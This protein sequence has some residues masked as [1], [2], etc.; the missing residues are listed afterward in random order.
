MVQ[1]STWPELIAAIQGTDDVMWVGNSY[2]PE[3]NL[4]VPSTYNT[5][6][7][8]IHCPSIDFNGLRIGKITTSGTRDFGDTDIK[9]RNSW[10][11]GFGVFF[12]AYFDRA[13]VLKNLTVDKIVL[14]HPRDVLIK[15]GAGL[16]I[17]SCYFY[18]IY[19][20]SA[21]PDCMWLMDSGDES[22]EKSK[23]KSS[24]SNKLR[25]M[26]LYLVGVSYNDA[27]GWYDYT[28]G[29]TLTYCIVN[30]RSEN[31][32]IMHASGD[33]ISCELNY[34]YTF[35][36]DESVKQAAT[37]DYDKLVVFPSG[38]RYLLQ[39]TFT[40]QITIDTEWEIGLSERFYKSVESS[41]RYHYRVTFLQLGEAGYGWGGSLV[42][43]K[44]KVKNQEFE[45]IQ[46]N[47]EYTFAKVTWDMEEE[48]PFV[49]V[50]NNGDNR[51]QDVP[52]CCA[53]LLGDLRNLDLMR[54]H[55]L[56]T[57]EDDGV[58]YDQYDTEVNGKWNEADWRR[59]YYPA[60]NDG[61]PFLPF[62]YYPYHEPAP[63]G[64]DAEHNYISIYDMD[65]KQ[66]EFDNNGLILEP[67]RCTV[68]E[69]LNGGYNLT[70]E[71]PKD[72][73]GKWKHILEMNIIKCLGQLFIIRKVT[74]ATRAG[75]KIITAY[76][77]HISYHL[78][79]YWLFP[80]TSIAGYMGQTLI[81][82]IQAQMWDVPWDEEN[83]L[84]YT[85][86]IK[87]NLNADPTF[88]EWYE[89][90]EGHTPWE[91]ILG[92]N[93]FTQLIGGEVYR[94]NFRISIYERMEGA[95]DNAF[96]IHPD[97]NL[98]SITRTV[99][100]NTFCTYFR[101]YDEYGGW[102][103]IAWDPRTLP[104]SYPHNVVRSQNFTFDVDEEY[105]DFS[106]LARKTGEYF[107][108]VCAPLVSFKMQVQDLK[109]HPDYKDFV[110]NYRFKVGDMG[111]VWDD[112]SERYYELEITKTVKDGITGRCLE[113]TIGTERSFTRPEASPVE[114]SKNFHSDEVAE[115]DGDTP[116]VEEYWNTTAVDYEYEI[117]DAYVRLIKYIGTQT[118]II[119]P[120]EIEGKP[121]RVIGEECFMETTIT[122]V[123]MPNSVEVIE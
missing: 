97:L 24:G 108:R 95:Q 120:S 88:K 10:M 77:E 58:R 29:L 73:T 69:E 122:A 72:K 105:Y 81:N 59:R 39:S 11:W 84:R 71:H 2:L 96:V 21:E 32:G 53:Y 44:T 46:E 101:G 70:L 121:V 34:D 4:T 16:R 33:Y 15:I 47:H 56:E 119:I 68:T 36:W 112:E 116:D 41:E 60:T 43:I 107:Q 110:N 5:Y 28:S 100:L 25:A 76:A 103:A 80:G 31:C 9:Q 123:K 92:S 14:E 55:S 62:W 74:S 49:F 118:A 83:N 104:R 106:M 23:W 63:S 109:D 66:D 78:N 12:W 26:S 117:I 98:K 61:I 50:T 37:V 6:T 67:T 75:S 30:V 111:K 38:F 93:G 22:D 17:T 115:H 40:A 79:D 48:A 89:M 45:G 18:D 13:A 20:P 52:E 35:D 51:F 27:T 86:D 91:M 1:V 82:S 57:V 64:G 85:F 94:S 99:D 42:N 65:T 114:T 87:T 19:A 102:F 113:V 54:R 8:T 90:P 3:V 7:Y